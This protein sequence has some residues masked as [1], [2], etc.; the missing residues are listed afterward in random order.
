MDRRTIEDYRAMMADAVRMAAY[1]KAI[2]AV[3]S[4]KVVCEIGVGLAPLSLMA[5]RAGATR[6]YGIECS[7]DTLAVATQLIAD[8][9]YRPDRFIPVH[10][11]STKISLPERVDVLLSETLDSMGI[12]E[13]TAVYMADAQARLMKPDAV[14]LPA[15][16]DCQVALA[17]PDG[18]ASEMAFWNETMPS[19]YGFDYARAGE[20]FKNCKHTLSISNDELLSGW[21]PW[22]TIDFLDN[23]TYRRL[24]PLLIPVTR[25]GTILGFATAFDAKLSASVHLRTFPDDPETH[26]HQ[27]FNAF[28][29]PIEAE[30]GDVVYMELQIEPGDTPAI[31][32]E[33]RVVCGKEAEVSAF[34]RQ[35]MVALKDQML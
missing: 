30:V 35:R 32:F 24:V 8:N 7:A 16:L 13:N 27:G 1:Q 28:P 23:A 25:A 3:C 9:G 6:V 21:V 15:S 12:G 2:A 5:L 34:V 10:G 4:G 31:R 19:V 29:Q 11:F 26:W 33:M 20:Q 14:F 17:S 18:Y 22:Q